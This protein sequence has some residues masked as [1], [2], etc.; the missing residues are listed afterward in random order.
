MPTA[1]VP[2]GHFAF[3]RSQGFNDSNGVR[4][5]K[6]DVTAFLDGSVVYG[7][8][9][10]QANKLR[11]FQNGRLKIDNSGLLPIIDTR[12]GK[13]FHAGDHRATE[14]P[15]LSSIQT[16]WVREHNRI[17]EEIKKIEPKLSDEAIYQR[18]RKKVMGLL[19]HI[20]YEEFLPA[21]L[22][23]D[24]ITDYKGYN[25][26]VNPGIFNEF[27]GAAYRFGHSMISDTVA[28]RDHNGSVSADGDIELKDAFFN[29]QVLQ[30]SGI[31]T[32]LRGASLQQARKLIPPIR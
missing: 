11:D 4:Q 17:C 12:E 30:Q 20:T 8:N 22:G 24:A 13:G 32:V 16:L 9:L 28:Q 25:N 2:A 15:L 23:E 10:E 29:I 3:T 19:Q 18:A 7:S 31:D 6:N 14:N 26:K 1:A 5:Q 27:A 21:L